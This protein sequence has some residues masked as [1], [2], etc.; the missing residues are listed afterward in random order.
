MANKDNPI[1]GRRFEHTVRNYYKSQGVALSKQYEVPIGFLGKKKV[2]AFD[3]GSTNPSMIVEC[4]AHTWTS[5]GNVPSAKI[6]V[7]RQTMFYFSLVTG[8]YRKIFFVLRS[9][10]NE[11][12]LADYFID[13]CA[14]LIPPDVEIWEFDAEED[15]AVRK[16]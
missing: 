11:E 5:G 9:T 6:S 8:E 7:W 2:H 10:R 3:L 4:K 16:Y 13:K 1:I 12:S 15:V 14:H